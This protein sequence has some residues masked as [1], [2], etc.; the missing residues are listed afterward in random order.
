MTWFFGS[1]KTLLATLTVV[2]LL[3]LGIRL[4]DLTDLPLDFHP[5]RQLFSMLK[6]RGMYYAMTPDL[7]EWQRQIA[8]QQW[9]DSP[10]IEPPLVEGLAAISYRL[11][12]E[13]LAIPRIYSSIFWLVGG[14]FLFA[15]GRKLTHE[16]GAFIALLFYLFLPYAV[17]ASRSFQPD[18]LMVMLIIAAAWG[19]WNWREHNTWRWAILAGLLNGLAIFVKN[20]A[21]FPLLGAALAL[22][23]ERGLR[24]SLQD[25][26]TWAVAT[27][28]VL[29]VGLYTIYGLYIAGFLGQQFSFRFFPELLKTAAFYLQWKGQLEGIFG[30]GAV[31]VAV[32]GVLIAR[33]RAMAFLLGLWGGYIAYGM[34]F[35]YHITTHDYYQMML[36]PILALS[37]APA[38][39]VLFARAA[40]LRNLHFA[41]AVS[42]IL[43]S[44]ML[45]LHLWTVR[46]ELIREDF[47]PDAAYQAMLGDLMGHS[48]TPA[49]SIAQDY[50]YRLAYW[51]W[52]PNIS[53]YDDGQ[54]NLRQLAGIDV[55]LATRFAEFVEGKHFFVITHLRRL[56]DQ[57]ALKELLYRTYPIFAEGDGYIIF[58]LSRPNSP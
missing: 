16:N 55:D 53:W 8:I 10:V 37:L 23:L 24:E 14:L 4:Y 12:G 22:V 32:T 17:Y 35:A 54:L 36:I 7:P 30:L 33:R 9:K 40:E 57:P 11:F 18:P 46:V 38:A 2:L 34:T 25:K 29:P 5:T 21:I 51:G 27:L 56:D 42:G 48:S 3:A 13:N 26:P 50:G 49:I 47:R 45:A 6:A 1:R 41:R 20:V 58:D 19:M 43:I 39:E 31:A 52:Q 28:S 15:L 44:L